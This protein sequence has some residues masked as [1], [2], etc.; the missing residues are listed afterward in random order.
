MSSKS[1][2]PAADTVVVTTSGN[3]S[4]EEATKRMALVV[5]KI[6]TKKDAR[7]LLRKVGI[8][9]KKNKLVKTLA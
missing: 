2:K 6:T 8:L 3:V 9:N 1:K 5:S 4:H 7:A